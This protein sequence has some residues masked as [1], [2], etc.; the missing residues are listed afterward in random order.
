MKKL[1]ALLLVVPLLANASLRQYKA[2]VEESNW[3]NDQPNRLQCTLNHRIPGY[4]T[5]SFTSMASKILNMEFNLDMLRLPK[6]YGVAA[7]YSVPPKWMPGLIHKT[8]ADMTIRKQFDGDLPEQA[9][10]TM[11]SELEK[12]FWPTL[13]YQDWYS[14]YDKVAVALNASNFHEPYEQFVNCVSNLLPYSFDD[15]KYTV[16]TY[17]FGGS[18][19]TKASKRKL[20]M[21]GAYLQ[22]DPELELVLLDGYTD[23]Y[24]G[25]SKNQEVSVQRA[26]AIRDYFVGMGVDSGRIDVT[27]H[28]ERRHA[29]SNATSNSRA[30]NRRVVIRM[31]KV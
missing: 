21:I 2:D 8:I 31:Q 27:G 5:A 12:G 1:L 25:K 23:S 24:G 17:K 9:A 6:S 22:E 18:E 28:G 19:L 14:E 29:A 4:G 3:F 7:V 15:I 13:Y 10:W 30:K 11:L 26:G 16:L 20:D